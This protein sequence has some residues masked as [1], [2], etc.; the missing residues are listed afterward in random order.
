M[1]SEII[2][3]RERIKEILARKLQ[4]LVELRKKSHRRY[5]FEGIFNKLENDI[6]FLI[7]NPDYVRVKDRVSGAN[8]CPPTTSQA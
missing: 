4:R 1:D 5:T 2:K 8:L 3:E 7:D 6:I